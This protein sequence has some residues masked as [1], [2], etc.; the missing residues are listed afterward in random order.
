M[1]HHGLSSTRWARTIALAPT[2]MANEEQRKAFAAYMG[3]SGAG[4]GQSAPQAQ[5]PGATAYSGN[6]PYLFQ[7]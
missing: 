6:N 7:V 3:A 5:A 1:P 2:S 4:G